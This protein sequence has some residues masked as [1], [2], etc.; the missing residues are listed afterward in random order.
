MNLSYFAIFLTISWMGA[1]VGF[2]KTSELVVSTK[3]PAE[4]CKNLPPPGAYLRVLDKKGTTR[5]TPLLD[6]KG[7]VVGYRANS[8]G[9]FYVM[10]ECGVQ[11]AQLFTANTTEGSVN[12]AREVDS[13]SYDKECRQLVVL[14]SEIDLTWYDKEFKDRRLASEAKGEELLGK[15]STEFVV[16]SKDCLGKE[17]VTYYRVSYVPPA[18]GEKRGSLK[19]DTEEAQRACPFKKDS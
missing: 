7:K 9:H 15:D 5:E 6:K 13:R 2:S 10:S 19:I 8:V 12:P 16:C 17:N 18:S 11:E 3:V 14:N 1:Q 4:K